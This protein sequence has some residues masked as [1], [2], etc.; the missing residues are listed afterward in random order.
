[1]DGPSPGA[2]LVLLQIGRTRLVLAQRDV[3]SLESATDAEFTDPPHAALGTIAAGGTAWPV[4]ALDDELALLRVVPRH[5]P[6]CAMLATDGGSF[7]LLCDE[8]QVLPRPGLAT[9]PLPA[10]MRRAGSPIEGVV[11]IGA[12]V[13]LVASARA[14]ARMTGAEACLGAERAEVS[15]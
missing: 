9:Y 6:I 5:R 8:A 7:G 12:E 10:A 13:A 14:L 4:F 1:V 11:T 15:E 3:R 2:H